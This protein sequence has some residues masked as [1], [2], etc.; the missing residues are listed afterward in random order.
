MGFGGKV[1]G[2]CIECP[3]HSWKF[4]GVNGSLVDVPYSKNLTESKLLK[5]VLNTNVII[6]INK[7]LVEKIAKVR[8]WINREVNGIVFVWYHAEGEEPWE[9][10]TFET[11]G[12]WLHGSNE[13]IV[14]CHI[15][16]IPENGADRG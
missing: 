1:K 4:S 12:M 11:E 16:D 5:T 7:Q 14:N 9:I 8:T 13:F 15:Q 3:F 2:N 10:S 6:I